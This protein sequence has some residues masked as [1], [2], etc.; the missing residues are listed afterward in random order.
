MR[1]EIKDVRALYFL[2]RESAKRRLVEK[3][4]PAIELA[5][6]TGLPYRLPDWRVLRNYELEMYLD[7][8]FIDYRHVIT[9]WCPYDAIYC[10]YL[11]YASKADLK[12]ARKDFE[13]ECKLS[14][15]I[16]LIDEELAKRPDDLP[17]NDVWTKSSYVPR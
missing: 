2:C 6:K 9:E 1:V 3:W 16:K 5:D 13:K 12:S 14:G 10:Q 7:D 17:E 8:N 15:A 11:R 4:Q